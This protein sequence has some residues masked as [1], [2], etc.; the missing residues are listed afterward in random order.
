MLS[1]V[2][3]FAYFYK[4][5]VEV[6]DIKYALPPTWYGKIGSILISRS[7]LFSLTVLF[8]I[9]LSAI[10]LLHTGLMIFCII[11]MSNVKLVKNNWH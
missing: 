3:L 7:Y 8:I 11:Y 1:T 5:S 4:L 6:K 2:I 10:N 9:G